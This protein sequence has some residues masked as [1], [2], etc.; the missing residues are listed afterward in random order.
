GAL[1]FEEGTA[2]AI[3]A[4]ARTE[5]EIVLVRMLADLMSF[6][7]FAVVRH[8]LFV[9]V[10]A[11]VAEQSTEATRSVIGKMLPADTRRFTIHAFLMT[12]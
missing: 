3:S 7:S 2:E 4:M 12:A 11:H 6:L 8:L 9:D 10:H 1:A 5:I